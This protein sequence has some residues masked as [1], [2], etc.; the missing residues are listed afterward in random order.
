MTNHIFL[1]STPFNMLTASMVAFGL[2]ESEN[3]Y[4]YL[5]D[6]PHEISPFVQSILDWPESPFSETEIVSMKAKGSGK[7]QQ[8]KLELSRVRE[9]VLRHCP[10]HIYTGNDR[11]IEFQY[12]MHLCSGSCIGHYID[13]GTYTYLSRKTHWLKDQLIDNFIKKIVYGLWWKQPPTIGASAWISVAHVAFPESVTPLLKEKNPQRLALDLDRPE[14]KQLSQRSLNH[15]SELKS[16]LG[17][18]DALLLLPHDSLLDSSSIKRLQQ[19]L[20]S[21]KGQVIAIKHHPRSNNRNVISAQNLLE[22]PAEQPL[23]VMLPLIKDKSVICGEISTALLTA[24][25]LRPDL[26]VEALS[27]SAIPEE[28]NNLLSRLGISTI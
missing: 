22:L 17:N 8:R 15:Y 23:E 14:F 16:S 12:A 20:N 28:W 27:S 24:K 26:K 7:R 9:K 11:R 25:C 18:I 2:P 1:A 6:Q 3:K 21:K 13:D 5:I 4:L 19:W 10:G